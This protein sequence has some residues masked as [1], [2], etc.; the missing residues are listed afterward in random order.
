MRTSQHDF[1][2]HYENHNNVANI[3]HR[4]PPETTEQTQLF[5]DGY[6]IF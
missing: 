3:Q 2:H 4:L 1:H 5:I 6:R